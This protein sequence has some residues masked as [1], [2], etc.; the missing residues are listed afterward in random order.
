MKSEDS[1]YV[2]KIKE[3]WN[4]LSDHIE[5]EDNGDLPALESALQSAG[6]ES[7]SMAKSFGRTKA[8]IPC[9]SHLS[10]RKHPP[11][12]TVMGLLTA[13]ID[14]IADVFR[15]SPNKAILLKLPTK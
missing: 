6:S 3:I 5:E 7:E 2:P 1:Y 10:A 4:W 12:A 11:F 9:R 8:N 15:K 14:H 13:P